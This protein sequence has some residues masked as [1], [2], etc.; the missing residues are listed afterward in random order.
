MI[1]MMM[2]MM[3]LLKIEHCNLVCL[4]SDLARDE[5]ESCWPQPECQLVS[6]DLL[7]LCGTMM[8]MMMMAMIMMMMV[9]TMMMTMM[10]VG[11]NWSVGS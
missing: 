4:V 5:K 9:V 3:M 8:I 10:T 7:L 6:S 1:M 2:M 11:R